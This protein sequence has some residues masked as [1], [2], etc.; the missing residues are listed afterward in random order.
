MA[1][2]FTTAHSTQIAVMVNKNTRYK[3]LVVEASKKHI[4]SKLW[5]A[6]GHKNFLKNKKNSV[7]VSVAKKKTRS[8]SNQAIETLFIKG[9]QLKKTYS[10]L[11]I[12]KQSCKKKDKA[13]VKK[14][15]S[16]CSVLVDERKFK[17][18]DTNKTAVKMAVASCSATYAYDV[19]KQIWPELL[20]HHPD[21][22]LL[23]GDNVYVDRYINGQ[24]VTNSKSFW[25]RYVEMRKSLYLYKAK[26]LIPIFATWDDHDY[27]TNDGDSSFKWKKESTKVF[28]SFFAQK[29]ISPVFQK[30]PGVSYVVQAFGQRLFLMDNRS[31]RTANVNDKRNLRKIKKVKYET[32]WGKAQEKWLFA[33]LQKSNTPA[34]LI[35][36]GQFF[37]GYLPWESYEASHPNNFKNIFLPNIKKSKSVLA[38]LSGDRHFFEFIKIPKKELGF[39]TYEITTSGIHTRL[40][41]GLWNKYFNKRQIFGKATFY[42]Y[43]IINSKAIVSTVLNKGLA[44]NLEAWGL[45]RKL[46]YKNRFKIFK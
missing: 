21:V 16:F 28:N 20:Q 9:L 5:T 34:W 6:L 11:V 37:G 23:I 18:L 30:G 13:C 27:G 44:V 10:L 41:P 3:Y 46:V 36:G 15:G 38:F 8:F 39:T 14:C 40:Y 42:N 24:S 25:T 45:G 33:K 1:Q 4:K 31:F 7:V 2:G 17:A 35:D 29:P 26:T 12:K 32:H 43:A 19:Q 22:I